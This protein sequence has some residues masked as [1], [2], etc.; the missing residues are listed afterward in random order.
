MT[1]FIKFAL[2]FTLGAKLATVYFP[3][4]SRIFATVFRDSALNIAVYTTH[5]VFYAFSYCHI[6]VRN[7]YSRN[8]YILP[9]YA[10]Q[11][12]DK[13]AHIQQTKKEADVD[14]TTIS[15]E[16]YK[17]GE[18]VGNMTYKNISNDLQNNVYRTCRY[19]LSIARRSNCINR[20]IASYPKLQNP[21]FVLSDI[22]FIS[23][24]VH[25][26]P[27]NIEVVVKLKTETDNFYIV[28]NTIDVHFIRYYVNNTLLTLDEKHK[29]AHTPF[30]YAISLIDNNADV[31]AF[32]HN[33]VITIHKSDYSVKRI[34]QIDD[35]VVNKN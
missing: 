11:F 18:F 17:E 30:T 13:L 34:N 12:I 25:L 10:K 3:E 2:C 21:P 9:P 14:D 16:Y 5:S 7:I 32:D 19:D 31:H 26:Q 8:S 4:Q 27:D 24:V 6:Q 29:H 35:D 1:D 15:V 20:A 22:A 33:D 28:G 23:F